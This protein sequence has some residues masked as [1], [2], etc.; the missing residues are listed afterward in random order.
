VG[1]F[2]YSHLVS[3]MCQVGVGENCI[4]REKQYGNVLNLMVLHSPGVD[5]SLTTEHGDRYNVNV[6]GPLST[7]CNGKEASVC[8]SKE[9]GQSFAIGEI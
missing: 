7:T 6:C 8:L 9:N 2:F 3:G 1:R 5:Y 4:V